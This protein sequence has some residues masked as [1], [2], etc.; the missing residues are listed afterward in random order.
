LFLFIVYLVQK[1]D[2]KTEECSDDSPASDLPRGTACLFNWYHIVDTQNHPCSDNNLYGF[3]NEE[4]CVLVKLNKVFHFSYFIKRKKAKLVFIGLWLDTKSR[5]FTI[6]YT[7]A[8]RYFQEH[9]CI[10]FR[11]LYNM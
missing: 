1:S 8:S 2:A 11:C 3:K 5:S 9:K 6:K 10:R 4:P 7:K